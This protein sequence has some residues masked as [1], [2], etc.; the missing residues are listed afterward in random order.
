M[1]SHRR[2]AAGA[3]VLRRARRSTVDAAGRVRRERALPAGQYLFHEGEPADRFFVVR[4][5]RVALDVHVPRAADQVVD[6]VDEGDVVGWSWLVPP[7]RWFFDA[8]AV[9]DVSAVAFDATC[10]RGKCEEDP[11][12]GYALMQRV[13]QVMYQPAA[14]GTG[15]A[16]RPVRGRSCP[17]RPGRRGGARCDAD[18]WLPRPFRHPAPAGTPTTQYPRARA[19]R[20][21]RPAVRA[22]ASSR[23]CRRSGVGEVPISISG[24]PGRPG[25]SDHTIRDVGGVTRALCEAQRRATCSASAAP[26]A[27]GGGSSDGV[28]GD[29]VLVA[30]G[31]GLAPL[32][33]AVLEVLAARA[34]YGRVRVLYGA[35]TAD[36]V[37]FGDEL[38]AG[39]RHGIDVQV[40]V[41]RPATRG[42]AGSGWSPS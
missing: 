42:P 2:P 37:L 4:R 27:R 14:V 40:T 36:D 21:Q 13:A 1:R 25:A 23:W 10:L 6:T 20:R 33:P 9:A 32:R 5:G 12:L 19:A 16:A 7:Y 28:G 34:D 11:A 29:I 22:R 31:I 26:S 41:D 38:A 8:R 18:P 17:L 15:P 3:P 35:R 39:R 30:G 24:D